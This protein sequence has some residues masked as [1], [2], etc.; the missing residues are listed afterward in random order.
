MEAE[1]G[2]LYKE[3]KKKEEKIETPNVFPMSACQSMRSL[4]R[5][6]KTP[7][8]GDRDVPRP[9]EGCNH[10]GLL[11]PC[12]IGIGQQKTLDHTE[13]NFYLN[14]FTKRSFN[15][16]CLLKLQTVL[17]GN[18]GPGAPCC[19]KAG[20]KRPCMSCTPATS[21]PEAHTSSYDSLSLQKYHTFPRQ[22]YCALAD[23]ERYRK[24]TWDAKQII[25]KQVLSHTSSP[26]EKGQSQGEGW[27]CS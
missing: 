21:C 18:S 22:P 3:E 5:K 26:G 17:K 7:A 23:P 20:S 25:P 2:K 9:A 19:H 16:S 15:N 12:L 27:G 11:G 13:C 4:A 1:G 24:L 6:R 10:G 8:L 14:G